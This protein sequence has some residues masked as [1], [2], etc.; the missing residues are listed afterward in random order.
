MY[1]LGQGVALDNVKAH[2]W[3]SIAAIRGFSEAIEV[4]ELVDKKMTP[5]QID[6]GQEAASDCIKRNFENCDF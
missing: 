3:L 2:M 1:A 6:K 4:R 5:A